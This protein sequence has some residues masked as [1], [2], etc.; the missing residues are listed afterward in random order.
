MGSV[1]FVEYICFIGLLFFI[2]FWHIVKKSG[3]AAAWALLAFVPLLNL[4]MLYYFAFSDWPIYRQAY[5]P[6]A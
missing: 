4:V 6:D 2:P 3:Y 1:G 5:P